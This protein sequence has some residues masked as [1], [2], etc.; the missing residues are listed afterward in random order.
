MTEFV[1]RWLTNHVQ[2]SCEEPDDTD[3]SPSVSAVSAFADHAQN[4]FTACLNCGNSLVLV[5]SRQLGRCFGCQSDEEIVVTLA[6]MAIR[7]E[8]T[9]R[10]V[11]SLV[12]TGLGRDG[13]ETT[14]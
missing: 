9:K 1:S 11:R 14:S 10:A 3:K 12:Q 7:R 8:R 13:T 6:R 2:P 4:E 5:E